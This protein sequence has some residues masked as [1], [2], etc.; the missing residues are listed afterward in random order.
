MTIALR[1]NTLLTWHASANMSVSG[2]N[3]LGL[4][5]VVNKMSHPDEGPLSCNR[6][7]IG[8]YIMLLIKI[9]KIITNNDYTK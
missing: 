1:D 9:C 4:Q 2:N 7:R 5:Y 3:S 8:N 6:S